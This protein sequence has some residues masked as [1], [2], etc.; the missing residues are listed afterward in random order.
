MDIILFWL[1]LS[2]IVYTYIGFPLLIVLRGLLWRKDYKKQEFS[3]LPSVSVVIS[4]YNEAQTIAEK[5]DNLLSLDY[6]RELLDIV[7]ASDGST[8]GTDAIVEKYRERG[9]NL[10]MLPHQGKAF[11]L[12]EA[13]ASSRGDVLVFSDANSIYRTDAIRSLVRPFVDPEVGGVAGNQI[14]LKK[15][16]GESSGDGERAY[17]GFD[18]MLKEFQSRAGN[19]LAATGAI[20][21][22][23]R[24]LF[25]PIPEGVSD[26]LVTSTGVIAQGYRLVFAAD[27]VAY[28]PVSATERVEFKRKVRVTVRSLRALM[29]IRSLLNPFV[30]GFYAFQLFS[31][32]VLRYLVFVPLLTL[33]FISPFLWDSGLLYQLAI[34]AEAGFYILAL[35]GL[36]LNGTRSGRLKLFTIPFYF[37]M[38]NAAVL[39]A[40]IQ[41]LRGHQIKH[42]EPQRLS[43]ANVDTSN[44]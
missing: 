20:Y 2:L 21:A 30:Y 42:W 10:L 18:R 6:P 33:V 41:V 38:V 5:L 11:A 37:C 31:H 22:I 4:A 36:M 12:N 43:P 40:A 32:K 8:D 28:E 25:R 1:S 29:R 35:L 34:T 14:Y 17:W 24:S 44:E 39:V 13:V 16:S 27:A 15:V 3:A 23:R 26:D 7:I 9:V 19:T